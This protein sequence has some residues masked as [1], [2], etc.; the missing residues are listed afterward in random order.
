[1]AVTESVGHRFIARDTRIKLLYVLL[2]FKKKSDIIIARGEAYPP[3]LPNDFIHN[4]SLSSSE[5]T[6]T[7]NLR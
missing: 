2:E 3:A 4:A 7:K 1:L 5:S 6:V